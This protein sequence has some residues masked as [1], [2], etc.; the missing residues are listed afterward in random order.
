MA[1]TVIYSMASSVPTS[2]CPSITTGSHTTY[3][4]RIL[5]AGVPTLGRMPIGFCEPL[6]V[7]LFP[8]YPTGTHTL[9]AVTAGFGASGA[10]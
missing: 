3:Y 5:E 8:F 4:L 7:Q 2:P 10:S 6:G 9:V 1:W